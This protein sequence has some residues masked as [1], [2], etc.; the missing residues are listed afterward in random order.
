MNAFTLGHICTWSRS[1]EVFSLSKAPPVLV[2]PLPEMPSSHAQD[3]SLLVSP[4]RSTS[5]PHQGNESPHAHMSYPRGLVFASNVENQVPTVA[6]YSEYPPTAV[7]NLGCVAEVADRPLNLASSAPAADRI[8]AWVI[9]PRFESNVGQYLGVK[10][11]VDI[12]A[13][14]G[15]RF[16]LPYIRRTKTGRRAPVS[17]PPQA[18]EGDADVLAFRLISEGADPD[19]VDILRR[20]IFVP[21][22]TEQALRAPIESRELSLRHGGVKVK[23]QLLLQVTEAVPGDQSYCCRLCPPERRP[24]YKNAPDALR[25]LKRDHFGLSVACQYWCVRSPTSTASRGGNYRSMSS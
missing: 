25:H 21:K 24:E 5:E 14:Y 23:W 18:F 3:G 17:A 12:P 7:G 9:D 10:K 2:Q 16:T 13:S 4:Y 6:T 15:M 1:S 20:W 11:M 22:V 8:G 19:V